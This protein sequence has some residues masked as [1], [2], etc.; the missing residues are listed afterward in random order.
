MKRVI[1]ELKI[2]SKKEKIMMKLTVN[3]VI[4]T[5]LLFSHQLDAQQIAKTEKVKIQSSSLNQE[6]EL[7]IYTPNNYD[8]RIHEYFNVI[9]VFDSQN[10]EFFDYTSSILRFISNGTADFIVVGI[11]SPT[12]YDEDYARNNDFLPEL[13][14]EAS[15]ARYGTYSGNVLNFMDYVSDEVVPYI[16]ENYRTMDR[17]IAIGHSLSASFILHSMIRKPNLFDNYIAVS[18]NLAYENDMI[19]NGLINFDY[20]QLEDLTYLY[21]SNADEGINYWNEWIPAREKVYDFFKNSFQNKKV[22]TKTAEYPEN[23]HLNTFPPSLSNALTYYYENI[24]GQQKPRLSE[25]EY[26]VTI[27]VTVRNK[28]DVVYIAGDQPGLGNWNPRKIKMKKTSDF[29]RTLK[30][31]LK[32][33]AQFKFTRGSWETQAVMEITHDNITIKPETKNQFEFTI[34]EYIDRYN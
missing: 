15:I 6:R 18:P 24:K 27:N 20:N 25:D 12:R 21:L 1:G 11:T 13:K 2:Y 34:E 17:S 30:V 32:S 8:K 28:N 33:P 7:L 14:T 23:G 22:I 5:L 9:Y 31:K 26:E 3:L 16:N 19:A 4:L 29:E 10:R